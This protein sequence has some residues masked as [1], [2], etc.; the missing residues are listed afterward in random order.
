[1]QKDNFYSEVYR[2]TA[3]I[4]AGKVATYGQLAAMLG[5]PYAA[6][7][8]GEALRNTPEY[9]DIP[10]HRVVNRAGRLAPDWAFGAGRQ[11]R[12]LEAE[13]VIF[14]ANEHVDLKSCLW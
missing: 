3:R 11:R 2:L 1:M 14:L 8:V 9:L 5:Q 4:P 13:G 7:R 10:T 6:R 12:L